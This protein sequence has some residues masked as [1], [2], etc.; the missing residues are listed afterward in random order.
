M[1]KELEELLKLALTDLN[2]KSKLID[3]YNLIE[4]LIFE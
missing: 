1:P 3:L 4:V 2:D